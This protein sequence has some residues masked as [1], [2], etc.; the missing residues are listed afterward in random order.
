MTF[1]RRMM[2][3]HGGLCLLL[4]ALSLSAWVQTLGETPPPPPP[5][6]AT[7]APS[8][9]DDEIRTWLQQSDLGLVRLRR[10]YIACRFLPAAPLA[11]GPPATTPPSTTTCYAIWLQYIVSHIKSNVPV[12]PTYTG[13]AANALDTTGLVAWDAV[14]QAGK[15]KDLQRLAHIGLADPRQIGQKLLSYFHPFDQSTRDRAAQAINDF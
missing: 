6:T 12:D 15:P 11:N 9:S 2:H 8:L 10:Q 5:P 3:W 4:I 14:C 13:I 7:P 1:R